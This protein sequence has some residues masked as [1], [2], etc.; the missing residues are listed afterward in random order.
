MLEALNIQVLIVRMMN[1]AVLCSANDDQLHLSAKVLEHMLEGVVIT[2]AQGRIRSV[3]PA[4]VRMTGYQ[5][6]ELIGQNPRILKSGKHDADFYR[7]MWAAIEQTGQWQ[8]EVRNL[9]KDGEE[10][11]AWLT[12]SS[13]R[14]PEGQVSHLLGVSSDITRR[15]RAEEALLL[16]EERFCVGLKN[17]PIT[18]FLVDRDLRLRWAYNQ[19][20]GFA[21]RQDL[22]QRADEV[23]PEGGAA[24]L[25]D[26]ERSVLERGAGERREVRIPFE[27][28]E[29]FYDVTAEP[30]RDPSGQIGGVTVAAMDI[31]DRKL[32]ER[33]IQE[34]E[35]RF[36]RL[37]LRAP[38]GI[39]LT[40]AEGG[41]LFVN[42]RWQELAGL[43]EEEARGYGWARALHAEDRERLLGEWS[44]IGRKSE[45][46]RLEDFRFQR[47]D[48]SVSWLTTS[49]VALRND[50]GELTGHL[51]A[52]TDITNLKLAEEEVRKEQEKLDLVTR[53]IGVG[54][55]I[56]SRDYETLWANE[57][58]REIYGDVVGKKCYVTYNKRQAI[59]PSCGVQEVFAGG[60]DKVV[61]EQMGFD[62]AG[63][64]VWAEI[65]ATPLKDK[66]GNITSALE[67]VFPITKRKLMEEALRDSEERFRL[68]SF[69]AQDAIIL[70]DND[71]RITFWNPAAERILGYS[72]QEVL[73]RD[74]HAFLMPPRF[75]EAYQASFPNWRR[76]GRGDAVGIVRELSALRKDG[77]E[78]LV[79]LSI[80]SVRHRDKWNAIGILRDVTQRKVLELQ[81]RQAQKLESIGQLAAGIAHEINT[82][83][84][85]IGDN[86][87]FLKKA[88][89][90]LVKV[91]EAYR[92]RGEAVGAGAAP[93]ARRAELEGP[94]MRAELEY[95]FEEIP[96]AID[97]TLEGVDRVAGIVRAMKDFSHP[98]REE[99]VPADLNR[100]IKNTLAVSRNEWKYIAEVET[101]LDPSLPEVTCLPGEINQ[102]LLNLIVN[103][104]QAIE[105][106]VRGTARKG[107]IRVETRR[108]GDRVETRVADDGTGIP[109]AIRTKVFDP[110]FTTKPVGKGTGQGLSIAY[111][112]VVNRHGGTIQFETEVGKG[113]TFII[114]LPV[115][116]VRT[117]TSPDLGET[118]ETALRNEVNA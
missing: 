87:T 9:R 116:P 105:E 103:A 109:E 108:R 84:Q 58:L 81:L 3:N 47:P 90:D 93:A 88:F 111:N 83:T 44:E 97:Q 80:S 8:G 95:L 28:R 110:F 106:A 69:A 7:N 32:A 89:D 10:Y 4:F 41:A 6:A 118:R 48:G 12:I 72:E 26:L 67:V 53:N 1:M 46:H 30:F 56:I 52:V 25:M 114:D 40:D 17:S 29:L 92:R 13:I 45:K 77:V 38:V 113:T 24:E 21:A 15:R 82:P 85:Y 36:R 34:T 112:V 2:D 61:H 59:C 49:V 78:I 94:V 37:M 23:L 64:R 20:R 62:S 42:Q 101:D 115:D 100:A 60:K 74:L 54:L 35:E 98:G 57:L 107:K 16:S 33:A 65:I 63:N 102:V 39:F 50:R 86:A 104:A 68:S 18:M 76:T 91:L 31:T 27:G 71:G 117:S 55:A 66:E 19:E 73:G 51:G 14:D 79:E 99:K 43:S 5:E 75:R 22:G 70:L 11:T 96:R